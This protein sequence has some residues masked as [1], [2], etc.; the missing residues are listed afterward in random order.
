MCTSWPADSPQGHLLLPCTNPC[1]QVPSYP[2]PCSQPFLP[3]KQHP[4]PCHGRGELSTS[5]ESSLSSPPRTKKKREI[6]TSVAIS[7]GS[8]PTPNSHQICTQVSLASCWRSSHPPPSGPS[9]AP[10][11]F[12]Q[13]FLIRFS[14]GAPGSW[15]QVCAY[16][17]LCPCPSFFP[18]PCLSFSIPSSFCLSPPF[19]S[20]I[21]FLAF[22]SLNPLNHEEAGTVSSFPLKFIPF[23]FN[24]FT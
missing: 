19:I 2:A 4:Q 18:S 13:S 8:F 3:R 12:A 23:P 10:C 7:D 21:Q 5:S 20:K 14:H 9:K 11:L 6:D 1:P 24:F 16:S 22:H 17:W 15:E